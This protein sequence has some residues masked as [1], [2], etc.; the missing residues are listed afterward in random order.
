MENDGSLPNIVIEVR[1]LTKKYGDFTAVNNLN[2]SVR[3][4]EV[5]GFIG[6]NGA[7]KTTTVNM[8][9]TLLQP[10][11]GMAK[12]AGFDIVKEGME[13]KK[14]IGY[15]P[16]NLQLYETMTAYE[17]LVYLG[18]LSGIVNPD[19]RILEVLTFL[20]ATGYK[21]KKIGECSKGMRQKIGIA[22]AIL[23]KP[24]VLFLDEPT[25]GLDPQGVKQLRDSV[26]K[27]NAQ[28][29]MTIFVNTHLLSEV[30]RMCTSLGVLSHGHLIYA[31]SLA[32]TLERFKNEESLEEIYLSIE[33]GGEVN[34]K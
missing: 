28:T 24:E 7:G 32:K 14:R 26:L 18:K 6:H 10:T 17:N 15:L 31:D 9:T 29:G 33:H 11:S 1:S 19:A 3:R 13:V 12:V 23:H 2:F 34:A 16:E 8:L 25:S 4:G 22:Q 27:L 21:D 5:F 20:D 30:T